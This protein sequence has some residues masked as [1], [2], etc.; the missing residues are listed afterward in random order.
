MQ[1]FGKC[2]AWSLQQRNSPP[3]TCCL[4]DAVGDR[5][6]KRRFASGLLALPYTF[7]AAGSVRGGGLA[8]MAVGFARDKEFR[9][10]S[11]WRRGAEGLVEGA[12]NQNPYFA[13]SP[14]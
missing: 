13:P 3:H 2:V 7:T 10:E 14:Q 5:T 11:Q 4:K 6:P 8:D 1:G 9:P 12:L